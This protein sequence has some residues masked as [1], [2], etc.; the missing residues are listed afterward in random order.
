MGPLLHKKWC[1]SWFS[2]RNLR[3]LTRYIYRNK[4]CSYLWWYVYIF[5]GYVHVSN[6]ERK[7]AYIHVVLIKRMDESQVDKRIAVWGRA[8]P[9]ACWLTWNWD[10]VWILRRRSCKQT[11]T[12]K[13]KKEK[14]VRSGNEIPEVVSKGLTQWKYR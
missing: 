13:K 3:D 7:I 4:M 9:I 10:H 2:Y 5:M 11:I 1:Y 6:Y 12:K 14:N 8:R